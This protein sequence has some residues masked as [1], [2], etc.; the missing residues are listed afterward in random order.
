MQSDRIDGPYIQRAVLLAASLH[1]RIAAFV[2][3]A[4]LWSGSVAAAAYTI[5]QANDVHLSSDTTVISLNSNWQGFTPTF[6]GLDTAELFLTLGNPCCSSDSFITIHQ[7]SIAGTI[8]GTSKTVHITSALLGVLGANWVTFTFP[9]IVN[10]TPGQPYV[11]NLVNTNLDLA[12]YL[13]D[14]GTY[15]G[16]E[17]SFHYLQPSDDFLFREGLQASTSVPEP[18]TFALLGIALA[19]LGFSRR[20]RALS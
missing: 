14:P 15:A 20:K 5:D 2:C 17:A 4:L 10:L 8:V 9:T 18:A 12:W 6:S 19:G 13:S 7:G 3:A 1:I 11:I 16:G